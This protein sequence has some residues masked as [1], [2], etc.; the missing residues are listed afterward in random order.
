M[1]IFRAILPVLCVALA[2]A[3][4]AEEPFTRGIALEQKAVGTYYIHGSLG[5]GV[6]TD[7]LVDTGSTYV[8][9]TRETFR[10]VKRRGGVTHLRDIRGSMASGRALNVSIYRVPALAIGDGC[11]L[12]DVEVAVVPGANRDIL[13]LSALRQ[14][15]PFAMQMEPPR[16]LFSSCSP[17]QST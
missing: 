1:T 6:E 12:R 11:V 15:Q 3:A 13:G 16:L 5:D 10:K 17:S 4:S 2:Q 9:L 14:L 7:L 8:A